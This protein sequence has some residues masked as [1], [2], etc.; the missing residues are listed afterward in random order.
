MFFFKLLQVLEMSLVIGCAVDVMLK[1][2]KDALHMLHQSTNRA[3]FCEATSAT[4]LWIFS[5]IIVH[6]SKSGCRVT[7]NWGRCVSDYFQRLSTPDESFPN[8]GPNFLTSEPKYQA[9]KPPT[10]F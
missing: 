1:Y 3:M 6:K 8:T 9:P 5:I 4:N 2:V 10:T 7:I